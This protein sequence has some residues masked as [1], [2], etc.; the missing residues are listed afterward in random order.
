[1][2]RLLR[3]AV[4]V[5]LA[6]AFLAGI[7]LPVYTDEVGWRF[8]ER[9][10]IDGVDKMFSDVCG[11]NSLAVPPFFMWPVRYYSA[12]FNLAFPEPLFVRLSGILYAFAYLTLLLAFIRRITDSASA[13]LTT[14]L[15][16]VALLCIATLPLNM[17]MSRPEQPMILAAMGSLLISSAAWRADADTSARAAWLRALAIVALSVIAMS[18]H[19]KSLFLLP[20][21][22]ACIVFSGKGRAAIAPRLLGVGLMCVLFAVATSYWVERL[23]CPD[24]P[25]LRAKYSFQNLGMELLRA[26]SVAEFFETVWLM[27]GHMTVLGYPMI[28]VPTIEPMSHWL[29][30]NEVT[31]AA[32][33]RWFL[34]VFFVWATAGVAALLAFRESVV[35]AWRERQLDPRLV[36]AF[37]IIGS[38]LAWSSTQRWNNVYESA[39]NLPLFIVAMAMTLA[40]WWDYREKSR[41]L[42]TLAAG[43]GIAGLVSMVLIAATWGPSLA[44]TVNDHGY[45]KDQFL[46]VSVFNYDMARED[47][48]AAAGKCD[49]PE[50][51]SSRSLMIDDAT[52]FT[53]MKSHRPQH[54]LGVTG[55]WRGSITDPVAY[56]KSRQS[57]GAIVECSRLPEGLRRLAKSQGKYCCLGPNQ[58]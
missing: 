29:K 15:F 39:F 22:A 24:D 27:L 57:D 26:R 38:L 13:R 41:M 18:Y 8:Q 36:I 5:A 19:V 31:S 9:A 50:P 1:M 42:Q 10:A 52:Y 58:W 23:Q 46:S 55:I 40:A 48:L 32:Q 11:A 25:L 37:V 28:T 7:F 20:L 53:Y 14:G 2:L 17:I 30:W 56:L 3:N 54:Y 4:V 49:I 33:T 45:A 35:R 6:T 34:F 21:F 43:L 51:E 16:A 12:W 44:R 47:I